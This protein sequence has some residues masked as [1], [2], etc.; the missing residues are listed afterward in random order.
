MEKSYAR[1]TVPRLLGAIAAL[2]AAMPATAQDAANRNDWQFELT[3]YFWAAGM[4]GWGRVGARTPTVRIDTDFSEIWDDLDFG[5][6]GTFEARK[7]RWGILFDAMYV[8]VSQRSRPLARG[9]GGSVDATLQQTILQTAGAYRVV[10]NERTPVDVLA[11][12]RYVYLKGDLDFPDSRILPAGANRSRSTDWTDGFIGVRASYALTD[13]WRL[14]GYADAGT[15][16]S[17]YSWQLIAGTNYDFSKSMV[18]KFGYRIISMKYETNDF[19]YNMKTA[20]LYLGL[21]I[22]F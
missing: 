12:I 17:D 21:G 14:I 13:R 9:L 19:L 11:G 6:M 15:G 18:G 1:H 20:G 3:P 5:A 7:G 22:R 8:K 10:D 2:A 4:N 16:G